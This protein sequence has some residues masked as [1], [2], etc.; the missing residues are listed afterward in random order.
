[1]PGLARA[2]VSNDNCPSTDAVGKGSPFGLD[3]CCHLVTSGVQSFAHVGVGQLGQR[4]PGR[5]G[6]SGT[7]PRRRGSRASA[8][9]RTWLLSQAP[10]LAGPM[11]ADCQRP[12]AHVA[13]GDQAEQVLLLAPGAGS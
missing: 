9:K 6:R 8:S 7:R 11:E 13:H 1:M 5:S 4:R 3:P 10:V 12:A 2:A